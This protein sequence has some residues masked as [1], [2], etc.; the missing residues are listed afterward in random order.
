MQSLVDFDIVIEIGYAQERDTPIALK[1]LILVGFASARTVRRRLDRLVAKGVVIR[2][3]KSG[4]Q[5]SA[6][7]TLSSASLKVLD[8][9]G[10]LLLSLPDG[11]STA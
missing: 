10:A 2:R 11:P 8:R 4:D 5:R 6:L 7:L 1:Q 9:Y 3:P